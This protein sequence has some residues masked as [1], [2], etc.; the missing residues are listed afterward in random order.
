MFFKYYLFFI[1][2]IIAYILT[3]IIFKN[4][5]TLTLNIGSLWINIKIYYVIIFGLILTFIVLKAGQKLI[6]NILM[7]CFLL[8]I[9]LFTLTLIDSFNNLNS[10]SLTV[11]LLALIGVIIFIKTK[12]PFHPDSYRDEKGFFNIN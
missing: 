1:P 6:V 10:H 12:S 8:L 7:F 11:F 9:I 5:D 3:I 2:T 4:Y